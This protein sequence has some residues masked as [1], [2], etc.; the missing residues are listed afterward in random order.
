MIS[1]LKGLGLIALFCLGFVGV[2]V[3]VGSGIVLIFGGGAVGGPQPWEWAVYSVC[4]AWV[5]AL[6]IYCAYWIG[7]DL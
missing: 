5:L 4:W 6:I 2:F 7:E 3:G 1:T